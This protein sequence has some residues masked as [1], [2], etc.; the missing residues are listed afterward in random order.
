MKEEHHA[1]KPYNNARRRILQATALL[2]AV[3]YTIGVMT[4]PMFS[5]NEKV[6]AEPLPVPVARPLQGQEQAVDLTRF[7]ARCAEPVASK[8]VRQT[9]I[10]EL[11]NGTSPYAAFPPEHARPLLRAKRIKGW[12]STGAVFD[13]LIREIQPRTILELGTFLGA[14][15]LHM[16][17][18]ARDRGLKTQIL[19][20]DDFRGWPGFRQK[21]RDVRLINGDVMLLFQFMQNVAHMNMTDSVLPL[22]FS[23]VA[24]LR[25]LCEMGIYADLI[26]V[27]AAHDFLSAWT[28]INTAYAVLRPGGVMFGHD[29]RTKLDNAGVRR[30]VHL[31]ARTRNLTVE[32]DGQH[33]ILRP[34]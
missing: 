24:M 8:L 23:T 22:P 34:L 17:A 28:D 29:Y 19:C 10:D 3:A 4:S 6:V 25:K 33:W 31:F 9:L 27:D 5:S 18:L 16:A 30:A 20:V 2:V 12:G 32:P 26:E 21:F 11:F 15:A 14:S 7:E 1:Q 13:R